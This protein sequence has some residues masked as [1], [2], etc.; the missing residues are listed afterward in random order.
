MIYKSVNTPY[1]SLRVY[2]QN[3]HC[4]P[5]SCL[6]GGHWLVV[7]GGGGS[8][9]G[10]NYHPRAIT[11][12]RYVTVIITTVNT[13]P[14]V[15]ISLQKHISI[16]ILLW[17]NF[18]FKNII[19]TCHWV[20]K[21]CKWYHHNYNQNVKRGAQKNFYWNFQTSKIK[22]VDAKTKLGRKWMYLFRAIKYTIFNKSDHRSCV[23]RDKFGDRR[24]P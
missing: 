6:L 12:T 21:R 24:R 2:W 19:F 15:S 10:T 14:V 20:K 13:N 18:V 17:I 9:E 16:H 3:Q 5:R 11:Q 7:E 22:E 23:L 8:G 1:W 4:L